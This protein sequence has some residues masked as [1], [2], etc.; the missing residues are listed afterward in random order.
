MRFFTIF[1]SILVF[2]HQACAGLIRDAESEHVLRQIADPIFTIAGL[3]KNGVNLFIVQDT[4]LNAFVAGGSNVFI[5]TGLIMACE[6]PEMLAGVIAHETG[7]IAGGHLARGAEQVQSASIGTI[8]SFVL[9]AAAAAGGSGEVGAAVISAGSETARRNMLSFSRTNEN[10]ADQAALNYLDGLEMSAQ[11]LLD[12]FKLLRRNEK[13]H[14]GKI[15]PYILT[16]P[17]SNERIEHMRSHI[18]ANPELA[19]KGVPPVL[20][21]N[22]QRLLGKLEGFLLPPRQVLDRYPLGN[23]TVRG[24]YARAVALFQQAE[25]DKALAT[26]DQLE[27][28][29]GRDGY[30]LDTRGQILF[31]SGRTAESEIIYAEAAKSVPDSALIRTSYAQAMLANKP[32]AA[33]TQKAV[34]Q[35]EYASSLDNTYQLTWHLLATA[36]GKQGKTGLTKLALAEEA[37]LNHKL[38]DARQYSRDARKELPK[39][40]PSYRRADDLYQAVQQEIRDE[41]KNDGNLIEPFAEPDYS[42]TPR[43]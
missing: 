16:H 29:V 18:D 33:K 42:I 28:K 15:D 19:E 37:F 34:E 30:L 4:S 14:V 41:K 3:D 32:D 9:G 13:M 6:R 8:I 43:R 24:L 35:L 36:Y 20:Q 17:L 11:G 1:L 12:T 31:E 7:H 38:R 27:K 25:P 40:S 22:Y 5:H 23:D 26:L 2:S 21:Q 10:A 39:D